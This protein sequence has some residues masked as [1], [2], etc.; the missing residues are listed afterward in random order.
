[1]FIPAPH[2]LSY[3]A[4]MAFDCRQTFL[5][6]FL[7]VFVHILCAH[8]SFANLPLRFSFPIFFSFCFPFRS[9]VERFERHERALN[10]VPTHEHRTDT[11]R[12]NGRK[13]EIM[14]KKKKEEDTIGSHVISEWTTRQTTFRVSFI[15]V[16]DFVFS[17][18]I[19]HI[20][21]S[22]F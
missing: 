17:L 6:F 19:V 9:L 21:S 4:L 7:S 14:K 12:M 16:F 2:V 3:D 13:Y 5:I 22:F 10:A 15:I 1:M 20:C 18:H 8:F 11:K